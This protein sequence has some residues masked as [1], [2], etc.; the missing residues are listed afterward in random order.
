LNL[1]NPEGNLTANIYSGNVT[2]HG[3]IHKLKAEIVFDE[4]TGSFTDVAG[5]AG[6]VAFSFTGNTDLDE[7]YDAAWELYTLLVSL[8]RLASYQLLHPSSNL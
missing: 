6:T 1:F 5:S 4:G 8:K 2:G 3:K 7:A